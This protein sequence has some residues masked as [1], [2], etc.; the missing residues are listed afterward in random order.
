MYTEFRVSATTIQ[1]ICEVNRNLGNNTKANNIL[2]ELNNKKFQ[3]SFNLNNF[4]PV[5]GIK[6]GLERLTTGYGYKLQRTTLI[7]FILFGFGVILVFINSYKIRDIK[8]P[9]RIIISFIYT[10][11]NILPGIDLNQNNRYD[12][13]EVI[14]TIRIYMI[15][16]RVWR[17]VDLGFLFPLFL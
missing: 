1:A 9:K 6:L 8:T 5:M 4:N 12:L 10:L 13:I 7:S 17:F 3:K 2:F 16:L 14:R 15:S 11:Y